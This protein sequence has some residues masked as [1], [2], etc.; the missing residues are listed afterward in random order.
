M[1]FD[2]PLEE[3]R[4]Q[5]PAKKLDSKKTTRNASARRR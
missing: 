1:E 5:G 4:S 3:A 2:L